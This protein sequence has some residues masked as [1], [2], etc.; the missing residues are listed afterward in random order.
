M[1]ENQP[2]PVITGF[3]PFSP[4]IM[5]SAVGGLVVL[6]LGGSFILKPAYAWW[7]ERGARDLAMR[8]R[9]A[10][11]SEHYDQASQLLVRAYKIMPA[12]PVVLR[13]IAQ[14]LSQPTNLQ[15]ADSE[16][17]VYFW[18]QLL[19]TDAAELEDRLQLGLV[20]V[21]SGNATEA[22]KLLDDVPSDQRNRRLAQELLAA[23]LRYD[24]RLMEAEQTL[25]AALAAEPD[26]P[27]CALRLAL[28]SV[29]DPV[30][31]T[32]DGALASLWKIA[33]RGGV[34]GVHAVDALAGVTQ[35]SMSE[36]EDLR[37][38][39]EKNPGTSERHRFLVLSA[40]IKLNPEKKGQLVQEE[41]KSHEKSDGTELLDFMRW[42]RGLGEHRLVL[43]ILKKGEARRTPEHF[44]LY[45][46][47]L[48]GEQRWGELSD[49]LSTSPPPP[50]STAD[51]ALLRVRCSHGIRD[52]PAVVHSLMLEAARIAGKEK[53]LPAMERAANL[54]ESLGHEDIAIECLRSLAG[55]KQYRLPM[56]ERI[57]AI[58]KRHHA[59]LDS[60]TT[61]K[62][63]LEFRPGLNPHVN[64]SLYLRLLIG[65]DLE[66]ALNEAD[67]LKQT[68]GDD[69]NSNTQNLVQALA[70]Y[71][72]LDFARSTE[73][74]RNINHIR[75]PAGLRAVLAGIL[76]TG[77][78]AG[79]AFSIAEKVPDTLL[80]SEESSF[81]TKALK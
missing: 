27:E 11:E 74:A 55:I 58:Q 73:I 49:L 77:G 22:Q 12:D 24:G 8:G 20:L 10:M 39:V 51:A 62:E 23:L 34:Q 54:A 71:R 66:S 14:L 3:R 25:R 17:A 81:L 57:L 4:Q 15:K 7:T 9:A 50:I 52:A 64:T 2:E 16:R 75:L 33:R 68:E 28:L 78:E 48:A 30:R 53:N 70:A 44:Q 13:A 1:P 18:K 61:L 63:I 35:L 72:R 45:T 47:A 76:K 5:L 46:D 60:L 19:A 21:A 43:S 32:R 69:A 80:F 26:N 31:A 29:N 56:L 6:I 40:W 79:K 67:A 59:G 36:V 41:W 38:L 65:A 42:L 37:Q